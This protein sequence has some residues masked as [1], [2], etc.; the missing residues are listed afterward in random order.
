[1]EGKWFALSPEDASR[2]GTSFADSGG[3]VVVACEISD[4]VVQSLTSID[5][6]DGIG[7]AMYA[8]IVD[9]EDAVIEVPES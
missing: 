8:E 9:L 3:F 2:W 4:V 7:P 6:L 5:R 1:M